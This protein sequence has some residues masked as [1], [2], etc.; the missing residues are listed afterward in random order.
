MSA[1]IGIMPKAEATP[2]TP[3]ATQVSHNLLKTKQTSKQTNKQTV[4]AVTHTASTLT[5]ALRTLP[6]Q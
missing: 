6:D 1:K 4:T 5:A 2:I 3:N